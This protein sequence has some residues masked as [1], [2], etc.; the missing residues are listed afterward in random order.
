[1]TKSRKWFEHNSILIGL[2]VTFIGML[3]WVF[4]IY[5]T[6]A[7]NKSDVISLKDH[8]LTHCE[9]ITER[10]VVDARIEAKLDVLLYLNEIDPDKIKTPTKYLVT[11]RGIE[12]D[13]LDKASYVES[14]KLK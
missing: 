14:L 11:E 6:G 2:A 10:K 3:F 8:Q 4:N 5:A 7:Q 1:M 12:F 9:Q 13:T